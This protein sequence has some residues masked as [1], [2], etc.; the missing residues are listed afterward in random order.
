MGQDDV[1]IDQSQTTRDHGREAGST[2]GAATRGGA[3]RQSL[4]LFKRFG[5]AKEWR[6]KDGGVG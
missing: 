3:D 5:V 1:T 4:P 2:R 6:V